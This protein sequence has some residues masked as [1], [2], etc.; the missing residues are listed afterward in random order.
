MRLYTVISSLFIGLTLSSAVWAGPSLHTGGDVYQVQTNVATEINYAAHY[1]KLFDQFDTN[2]DGVLQTAELQQ[3][4]LT[5]EAQLSAGGYNRS[6]LSV[7]QANRAITKAE[8]IAL[9]HVKT[10]KKAKRMVQRLNPQ[11]WLSNHVG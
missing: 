4:Q 2:H 6:S 3:V 1:G 9:Q 10:A 8:F 5:T 7:N 11:L